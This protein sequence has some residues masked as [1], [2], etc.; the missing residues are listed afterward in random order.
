MA[1]SNSDPMTRNCSVP[2]TVQE[3][4]ERSRAFGPDRLPDSLPIA[5]D[6]TWRYPRGEYEAGALHAIVEEGFAVNTHVD[7]AL[8]YAPPASAAVFRAAMDGAARTLRFRSTGTVTVSVDGVPLDSMRELPAGEPVTVNVPEPAH[9][10]YIDI[11]VP[12]GVPA[13]IV[14][15]EMDE[16]APTWEC[17]AGHT[18]WHEPHVRHGGRTP[19]HLDGEMSVVLPMQSGE[20]GLYS[21]DAPVLGYL[22]VVSQER[23][24]VSVGES[25]EEALAASGQ[26]SRCS[27]SQT[28]PG[29]WRSD[30]RV[31]LQYAAV[32][33]GVR[34]AE[35]SVEASIRPVD[36]RGAFVSDDVE[37]NRIWATS[38]YTLRACMQTVVLDGIKRDR[39][40]WIGDHALSVITNAYTFAD[41]DVI[42]TSLRALGRPRQGFVN[43]ISD[44]SLWWVISHGLYQRYFHDP[45]FLRDEADHIHDFISDL[46]EYSQ[47][48]GIFRPVSGPDAFEQSGPGSVF[49]D[50]GVSVE[51]GRD[52]T[53]LQILWYWALDT[54]A[55]ILHDAEHPGA[56]HWQELAATLKS[57]LTA[58]AWDEANGAWR[59]YADSSSLPSVYPNFLAQLCGL[60]NGLEYKAADTILR[61]GKT[62][63]P[64]MR[65]YA[66][67]ALAARGQHDEAVTQIRE[68]WGSMLKG[69]AS[70]FWEEFPRPG[71]SPYEM[72]GRPFGKSLCHAWSAGPAALLPRIVLGVTPTSDGWRQFEVA[73]ALGGLKWASAVV[74]VAGG[75][76]FVVADED[77]VRVDIPAGH[78]LSREGS[79]HQGPQSIS[80]SYR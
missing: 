13:A 76:I 30:H 55:R 17:R 68:S 12:R 25:P 36:R 9:Y 33:G 47:P 44:Y 14:T 53:A 35:I 45:V 43:G 50:W 57:S 39:M 73:P 72:Y 51:S 58:A 21:L 75:E 59:E 2:A 63:T 46:A 29:T 49:L 5:H 66:L 34:P 26:E 40:P 1:F 18:S 80:W 28:S 38:A 27:L 8:N 4:V 52:S 61:E 65:S 3:T 60:A 78:C 42:R 24:E 70:A 7:Y 62:G 10:A 31:G 37:L 11:T 6:Y 79:L 54:A 22:V 69:G 16:A 67:M 23:P 15:L 48:N 77:T 19:P 71:E 56:A 20:P 64:F 32:R 74:P 41:A